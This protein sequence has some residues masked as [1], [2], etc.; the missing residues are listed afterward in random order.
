MYGTPASAAIRDT[1]SAIIR[2]CASD[3]IT[4][5]P[6]IKNRGQP[7]PRRK[8]PRLISELLVMD[9]V[10]ISQAIMRHDISCTFIAIRPRRKRSER[11]AGRPACVLDL[12]RLRA[13]FRKPR[14]VVLQLGAYGLFC[15]RWR[16]R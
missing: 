2:A 13:L 1:F 11:R 5:G 6:A 8:D 16:R 4:H 9:E 7:A 3:S 10:K 12:R 14:V 15:A